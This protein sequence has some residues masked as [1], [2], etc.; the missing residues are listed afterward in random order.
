MTICPRGR[1]VDPDYFSLRVRQAL[2]SEFDEPEPY[3]DNP[4]EQVGEPGEG[5]LSGEEFAELATHPDV[6]EAA[7]AV[8]DAEAAVLAAEDVGATDELAMRRLDRARAVERAVLVQVQK[9]RTVPAS[10]Q[11]VPMGRRRTKL[12]GGE[13]A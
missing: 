5:E 11:I 13:A 2:R 4:L 10:F 8:A 6:I 9:A 7:A 3:S 12:R 1:Q